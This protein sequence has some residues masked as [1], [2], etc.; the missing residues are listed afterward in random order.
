M[1]RLI[2]DAYEDQTLTT[3]LTPQAGAIGTPL[4]AGYAVT[5]QAD[6]YLSVPLVDASDDPLVGEFHVRSVDA[7]GF[8]AFTGLVTLTADEDTVHRCYD[9]K[10]ARVVVMPSQAAMKE[11]QEGET[12]TVFRGEAK[13]I[14][15]TIVDINGDEV[16]L[17]AFTLE[18]IVEDPRNSIDKQVIPEPTITKSGATATIPISSTI[19]NVKHQMEWALRDAPTELVLGHGP[20]VTK[21]VP[22]RDA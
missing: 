16:D 3:F 19:S 6:G 22:R 18:F 9:S 14:A 10:G 17:T 13:S 15:L 7:E 12:L 11:A 1:S 2:H 4:P 8:T 5:E 20:L 21:Y